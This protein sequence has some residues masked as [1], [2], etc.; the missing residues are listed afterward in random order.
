M[1]TDSSGRKLLHHALE[2]WQ[3]S[4]RLTEE[5]AKAL[6]ETIVLKQPAQQIA[7][8]FFF[9]AL[10]CIL[11]AFGA[12]FL[13]EKLLEKIKAYFALNDIIISL[14]SLVLAIVWFWYTGKKRTVISD[15][16][17]EVYMV[18][19][20]LAIMT[21]LVYFCKGMGIDKTRTALLSLATPLLLIVA[22][23]LRSK[24]L[25]IAAII[26]AIGW[27][28]S[29]S[30][31]QSHD[32][33]FLGMNYPVRY[34]VFG[35]VILGIAFLQTRIKQ[36]SFGQ[37]LTYVA[38]LI[39]VFTGLWGMSIF[40]NYNTLEEWQQVRQV[41]VLAYSVVFGLAAAL[42]FY[43]GIRY[44]DE[45]ARD[46]GVLFLLINLYTR[47]FEYFWDT[48]NKGIF[49]LILAITFGFLG[50]WL[51]RKKKKTLPSAPKEQ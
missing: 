12:I 25:W 51:E 7:Q 27:F 47:Y 41:H 29:F 39:A 20:G 6:K 42:S 48:M 44:K 11:M 3:Q 43:L 34:T 8:Y 19:G 15:G 22:Q 26:T 5:Q 40:G 50:W 4:G 37:R 30:T 16:A 36:V 9:I 24:A 17:Y 31:W 33:L 46:M 2:E 38:G 14:I 23:L 13:N 35:L 21:A 32:N 45:I 10:F 1:E 18:L 49:F 28:G